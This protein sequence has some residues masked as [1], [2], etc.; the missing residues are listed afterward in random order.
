[1]DQFY[2]CILPTCTKQKWYLNEIQN[3]KQRNKTKCTRNIPFIHCHDNHKMYVW[4]TSNYRY[5]VFCKCTAGLELRNNNQQIESLENINQP[6]ANQSKTQYKT[7]SLFFVDFSKQDIDGYMSQFASRM[8]K[9]LELQVGSLL[10]CLKCM[11]RR[12]LS[13]GLANFFIFEIE[14]KLL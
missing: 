11:Q 8:L 12:E 1:M 9:H 5:V 13:V 14:A 2:V 7:I 3:S 6:I 10:T 4:K